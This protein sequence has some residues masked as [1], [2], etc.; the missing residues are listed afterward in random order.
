MLARQPGLLQYEAELT[1]WISDVL[2]VMEQADLRQPYT[3]TQVSLPAHV[4]RRDPL[5]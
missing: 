4:Q 5:L 1:Y 3:S 2:P